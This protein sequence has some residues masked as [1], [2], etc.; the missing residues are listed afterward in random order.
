LR[1]FRTLHFVGPCVTVFGSARFT[2]NHPYYQLAR[3]VGQGLARLGLTVMTGGGPGLMEAANRGAKDVGG[4]SVGCN[5]E[6]PAEQKLNAYLD[7]AVT[8]RHFFVRKVMLV[9]YSYAF[10][11]LPGGFGTMDE[12]F[13]AAVL[14]QTKKIQ[15]FPVVLMEK[16]YWRPLVTLLH[17]M[18]RA[19]TID[20][21]DLRLCLFTDSV[22]EAMAHIE[23]NAVEAFHLMRRDAPRPSPALG[24]KAMR[25]S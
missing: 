11:I 2:E 12:F 13:E 20:E 15:S 19:G 22:D 5:I 8:F 6:L 14:I 16:N 4:F 1:G 10:V 25:D 23:K 3:T 9:K 17:E 24:E 21:D 7:R 18:V